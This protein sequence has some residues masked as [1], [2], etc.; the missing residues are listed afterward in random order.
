MIP[1][2]RAWLKAPTLVIVL[3]IASAVLAAAVIHQ[4][5]RSWLATHNPDAAL[6]WGLA[7]PEALSALA[8]ERFDDARR[9]GHDDEAARFARQSLL[10]APMDE[11]A[12]RVLALETEKAGGHT[13]AKMLMVIGDQLSRRDTFTE[14]WLFQH[15]VWD[16]DWRNAS[17]HADALLRRQWQLETVLYPAMVGALHDPDAVAPFVDRL[18]ETPDWRGGFLRVLAGRSADP[19]DAARLFE[20]LAVSATPPTDEESGYIVE[21]YVAQGDFRDARALW[22]RLLP[23]GVHLSGGLV[24]NGDFRAAP[25]APPF[26]WRLMQNDGAS[27]EMTPASDGAPALHVLAPATTNTVVAAQLL[28]LSPGSYRLSG[29]ALVEPGQ[30]GDLFAWRLGCVSQGAT[31]V[32]EV[33]QADGS[34]GWRPFSVAFQVPAQGCDAQWLALVGLAHE[35]FQ[36][37][38]GWYRGLAI[39]PLDVLTSMH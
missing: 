11:R 38:E 12:L 14:T 3:A 6:A 27:A 32:A 30:T 23:R 25:G 4:A 21:R 37:A 9:L 5:T 33:R 20:A 17:L 2:Q 16:Q 8:E 19:A 35:G 15:A 36:Q 7:S 13:R 22:A 10:A 28:S 26:N 31:S 29:V 24:Y 1:A 34:A 39:Q 18:S